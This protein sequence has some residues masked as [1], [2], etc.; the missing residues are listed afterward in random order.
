MRGRSTFRSADVLVYKWIG[1]KHARE[2]LNEISPLIAL[3]R[4][5]VLL[6]D[7]DNPQNHFK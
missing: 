5:E 4:T 2:D 6:R 3:M 7:R 1:E